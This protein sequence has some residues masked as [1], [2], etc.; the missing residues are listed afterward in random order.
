MRGIGDETGPEEGSG[1]YGRLVKKYRIST[2]SWHIIWSRV[3]IIIFTFGIAFLFVFV[4]LGPLFAISP[5]G[6]GIFFVMIFGAFSFVLL[7]MLLI[8][9]P[10]SRSILKGNTIQLRTMG[11]LVRHQLWISTP[12]L[13][14]LIPYERIVDI[15]IA[16]EE[17]HAERKISTSLFKRFLYLGV[18][19]PTGGLY[20]V[21][22]NKEGFI[23]LFLDRSIPV[24]TMVIEKGSMGMP[25]FKSKM[26]KEVIIDVH[27]DD[28]EDLI[29]RV[30][31]MRYHSFA[32]K[33]ARVFQG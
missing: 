12:I 23:I 1:E 17:Y 26:V 22:S 3:K 16:D 20:H 13:A 24:T 27:P 10:I 9:Y 29:R 11:I 7:L 33:K 15:K 32:P 31:E 6:C 4:L 14:N 5:L 30:N 28:H 21:Y 19:P 25:S 2:T 8:L 18:P